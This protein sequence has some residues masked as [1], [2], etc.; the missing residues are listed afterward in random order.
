MILAVARTDVS[1]TQQLLAS[2]A[3]EESAADS[4]EQEPA[5]D[6]CPACCSSI[7][8]GTEECPDCGIRLQ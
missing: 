7:A 5:E 2:L 6:A 4:S 1:G 3:A 8:P